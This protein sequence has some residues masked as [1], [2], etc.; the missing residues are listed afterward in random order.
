M[1]K[2]KKF[3]K[4]II[5][6]LFLGFSIS[7]LLVFYGDFQKTLDKI[8]SFNFWLIIPILLLTLVNYFFRMLRWHY[9]LGVVGIAKKL[10]FVD[11]GLIFMSG[12]SMTVT[13]GRS[14]EVIK[15][16]FLKKILKNH[17]SETVP[18]IIIERLTDG[19]AAL[20]LMAGGLLLHQ[21]GIPVFIIAAVFSFS[22][23]IILQQRKLSFK[24]LR[25]LERIPFIKKFIL[26]LER[27]YETS[28]SLV[29]WKHIFVAILLGGI[30]WGAESVGLYLVLLGLGLVPS[31]T[32]FFT[33][34]FIFCFAGM[35]GFATML[36]GGLGVAEGTTTGLLILFLNLTKSTAVAATLLIRL[37]TLWFGVTLGFIALL[38]LLKRYNK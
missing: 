37:M 27:V 29:Q 36:P 13:P 21:Y 20:F 17:F 35:I 38:T 3:E 25:F 9:F 16:Y 8:L 14:G 33:A 10:S 34:F 12:L 15:A 28:Y 24:I 1:E 18:V 32:L 30:A 4:Q 11:S 22:I 23:V 6:A 19:L 26:T 7:A 31:V 2:I 5:I